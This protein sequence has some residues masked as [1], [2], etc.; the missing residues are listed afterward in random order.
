MS[1]IDEKESYGFQLISTLQNNADVD[2]MLQVIERLKPK[3]SQ[4][5]N[6]YCYLYGDLPNDCIVGFGE[7]PYLAMADFCNNFYNQKA[8]NQEVKK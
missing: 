3:F 2:A 4:D 7:T 5:G 1:Y 8:V 6:M